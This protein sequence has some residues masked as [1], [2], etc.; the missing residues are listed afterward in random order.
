MA[1]SQIAWPNH[2]LH[3]HTSHR[4]QAKLHPGAVLVQLCVSRAQRRARHLSKTRNTPS[5]RQLVFNFVFII[6]TNLSFIWRTWRQTSQN[7]YFNFIYIYTHAAIHSQYRRQTNKRSVAQFLWRDFFFLRCITDLIFVFFTDYK[8]QILLIHRS[9]R[10]W[11]QCWSQTHQTPPLTYLHIFSHWRLHFGRGLASSFLHG[12]L[13]R[14]AS[15][16]PG[17]S[18]CASTGRAAA[19]GMTGVSLPTGHGPFNR[20]KINALCSGNL[21]VTF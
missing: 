17:P 7:S 8:R 4:L 6:L 12:A 2:K 19:R 5:P 9:L 20:F 16:V 21:T 14:H 3:G 15:P 18:L 13:R 10:V 1:Q 11:I